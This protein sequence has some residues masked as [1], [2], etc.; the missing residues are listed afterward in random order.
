MI[1]LRDLSVTFGTVRAV[2]RVTAGL[3]APVTGVIGPN[4]AGKTTILSAIAGAVAS[5]GGVLVDG[6]DI[7][8]LS[9]F[10]RARAGIRRTFQTD[11]VVGQLSVLDNVRVGAEAAPRSERRSQAAR[12]EEVLDL[13]DSSLDPA[14]LG[15]TL[16]NLERRKVELARSLVGPVTV[17][18]L[19]EPGAGLLAHEKTDLEEIIADIPGCFGAQVLLIEHDIDLVARV[20]DH[21]IVLDFGRLIAEGRPDEVLASPAVRAAYLGQSDEDPGE[22]VM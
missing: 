15:A 6:V 11:Q 10:S 13:V 3:S 5:S 16:T 14:R 12:A 9:A 2:D 18:L 8:H 17:V 7:S 21:T 4:G 20:C 1:E 22:V 19:D